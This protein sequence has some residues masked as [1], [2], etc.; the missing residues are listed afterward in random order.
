MSGGIAYVY[1]ERGDFHDKSC[2]LASVDLEP[3]GEP[4]MCALLKSLVE[5]HVRRTGSPRA[6]KHSRTTGPSSCRVSSRFIRT[7]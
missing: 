4:R 5:E 2:N 1:D 3:V 7:N 6:T